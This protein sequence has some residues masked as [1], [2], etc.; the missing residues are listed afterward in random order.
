M[1]EADKP[2]TTTLA[3]YQPSHYVVTKG[4]AE[5]FALDSDDPDGLRVIALRPG[6]IYGPRENVFS[7]KLLALG[8]MTGSHPLFIP[9]QNLS[10]LRVDFTFV[11]NIVYAHMLAV[12]RLHR[13]LAGNAEGQTVFH[14]GEAYYIVDQHPFSLN[15]GLDIVFN[16]L[17]IHLP[18]VQWL[19]VPGWLLKGSALLTERLDYY[20]RSLVGMRVPIALTFHEA[21]KACTTETHSTQKLEDHLG[22]SPVFSHEEGMRFY[23]EDLARRCGAH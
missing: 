9:A 6:G 18:T 3:G 12:D 4:R 10:P 8:M 19:Y 1:S 5:Q 20:A 22:W 15:D 21:M 17:G 16:A 13:S 14:G 2:Y 11:Y 7:A 23:G